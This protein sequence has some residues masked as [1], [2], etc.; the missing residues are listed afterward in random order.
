M[1][2]QRKHSERLNPALAELSTRKKR[3]ALEKMRQL[4]AES[5]SHVIPTLADRSAPQAS[6]EDAAFVL[7]ALRCRDGVAPLIE[8]LAQGQPSLS[9]ACGSALIEIGSRRG[10]RELMRIVRGKYPLAARQEAVYTLWWLRETRAEQ[11]FIQLSGSVHL[12]EEYTRGIATEALGNTVQRPR[13]QKALRDR[14]FDP[15]I[16]V[17]YS[18]LCACGMMNRRKIPGLLREALEA[19]L[20]DPDKVDDDR[21]I[22]KFAAELLGR[23]SQ[24]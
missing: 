2:I 16:S 21:V 19:K 5:A 1:R 15:S 11:V 8:V 23:Y 6:R 20:T 3:E 12:E 7:G 9:S 22:A 18:A 10:S 24:P 13:S 17:R 14:L 4:G